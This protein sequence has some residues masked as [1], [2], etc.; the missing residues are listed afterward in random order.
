MCCLI[1]GLPNRPAISGLPN[2]PRWSLLRFAE[3]LLS[4]W[5]CMKVLCFSIIME[6]V[7][8][9]LL[10]KAYKCIG[11]CLICPFRVR[12]YRMLKMLQNFLNFCKREDLSKY[13]RGC[14][15]SLLQFSPRHRN[16]RVAVNFFLTRF[17][18]IEVFDFRY[19]WYLPAPSDLIKTYFYTVYHQANCRISFLTSV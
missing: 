18:C 2:R 11:C 3:Q 7:P 8:V 5:P 14:Q 9:S 10:R 4:L 16:L 6:R 19:F 1:S 13:C 15:P 17:F 12:A